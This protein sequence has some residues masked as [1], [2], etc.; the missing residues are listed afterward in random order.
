MQKYA[1]GASNK[2]CKIPK[3]SDVGILLTIKN[4]KMQMPILPKIKNIV[5]G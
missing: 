4:E 3:L 1:F 2:L 5:N